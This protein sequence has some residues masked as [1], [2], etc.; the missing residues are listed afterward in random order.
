LSAHQYQIPTAQLR[1]L[2]LLLRNNSEGRDEHN[3]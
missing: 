1:S 2:L 3:L